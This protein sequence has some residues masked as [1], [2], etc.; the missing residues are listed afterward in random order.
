MPNC[1]AVNPGT[2][3]KHSL[4]LHAKMA[5]CIHVQNWHCS[6][7]RFFKQL[8]DPI[9]H[10]PCVLTC[11]FARVW[12]KVCTHMEFIRTVCLN[13]DNHD[14]ACNPVI[15][16]IG[17]RMDLFFWRNACIDCDDD[18][19]MRVTLRGVTTVKDAKIANIANIGDRFLLHSYNIHYNTLAPPVTT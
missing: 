15:I 8:V 14:P 13:S 16:R 9:Q 6:E 4:N 5:V 2:S 7:R 12:W 11:V 17:E 3:V 18:S 1:T 19:T 10:E